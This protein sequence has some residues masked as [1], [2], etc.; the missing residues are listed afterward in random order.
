MDYFFGSTMNKMYRINNI[1]VEELQSEL[2]THS[3]KSATLSEY[4]DGISN[5]KFIV[6]RGSKGGLAFFEPQKVQGTKGLSLLGVTKKSLFNQHNYHV[7]RGQAKALGLNRII[8][9]APVDN[10]GCIGMAK[11]YGFVEHCRKNGT[12]TLVQGIK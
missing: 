5:R 3:N 11:A 4:V 12:V 8:T 7:W 1:S 2:P 9:Q 10:P 6:F